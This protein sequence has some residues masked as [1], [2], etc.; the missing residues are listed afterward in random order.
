MTNVIKHCKGPYSQSYAFSSSYVWMCEL[1]HKE[2]WATKNWC[3]QVEVLKKTLGSPLDCKE[4]KPVNPKGR[5]PWIFTGRT[6][7]EAPI[8]SSVEKSRLVGKDPD[9]GKD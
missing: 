1:D 8:S 7:A 9:A 3:F 5:Q 4:I 2:G 6:D